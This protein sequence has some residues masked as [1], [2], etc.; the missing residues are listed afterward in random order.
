M[1]NERQFG[2]WAV[3]KGLEQAAMCRNPEMQ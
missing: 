1:S 3:I 2:T